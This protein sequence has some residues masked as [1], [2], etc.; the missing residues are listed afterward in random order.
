MLYEVITRRDTKDI[1]A[2]A[3]SINNQKVSGMLYELSG[4]ELNE[5]NSFEQPE[6][7]KPAEQEVEFDDAI[8]SYEFAKESIRITSYNVCYTKLLRRH[9]SPW[10]DQAVRAQKLQYIHRSHHQDQPP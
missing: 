6:R 1:S 9:S 2:N 4:Y 7:I 8:F 10:Q 3:D 5:K